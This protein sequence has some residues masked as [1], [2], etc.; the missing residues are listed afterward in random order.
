MISG[1]TT[2]GGRLAVAAHPRRRGTGRAGLP[3][4]R[5][6][7]AGRIGMP[8]KTGHEREREEQRAR[9]QGKSCRG[10][11]HGPPTRT[12]AVART[13]AKVAAP[14]RSAG[15]PPVPALAH[16]A[17]TSRSPWTARAWARSLVLR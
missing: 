16:A 5:F 15:H 6:R 1:L 10:N 11:P 13:A 14:S 17:S 2:R 12:L 3:A 4:L 8:D 7:L 9:V